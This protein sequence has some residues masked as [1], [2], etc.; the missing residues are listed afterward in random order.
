MRYK[1]LIFAALIVAAVAYSYIS[2]KKKKDDTTFQKTETGLN[3]R[4]I[5]KEK[6]VEPQDGQMLVLNMLYRTEDGK[7]LYTTEEQG[8]PLS[9]QYNDSMKKKDGGFLEAV[10]MLQEGDSMIFEISA[11]T[12]LNENFDQLAPYYNF[13]ENTPIFLHVGLEAVMDKD[14]FKKWEAEKIVMLQKS[15]QEANEA[16][17]KKD[18]AIIDDY[19]KENKIT[20]QSTPSGLK[21]SIHQPGEGEKLKA[22]NKIKINYIGKTLEGSIFDTNIEEIAKKSS[23]YD[24]LRTYEPIEIELGTY[25]VIPGWEEGVSLLKKGSKATFFIPSVLAY[26]NQSLGEHIKPH[27]NLIFE[28]EVVDVS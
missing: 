24:S 3:F 18:L 26:G 9:L 25:K 13:E 10:G 27:T 12:L 5:K 28:V 11:K 17:L 22:G 23:M 19:L 20:A 4:I 7:V 15:K 8:F 21:Y 2:F 6:G 16:Q 1:Y 14:D